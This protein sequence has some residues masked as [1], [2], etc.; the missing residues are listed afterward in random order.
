MF[1]PLKTVMEERDEYIDGLDHGILDTRKEMENILNTLKKKE[2][3]ARDEAHS[4]RLSLEEE[5]SR[6]S[7][8]IHDD[9]MKSVA[10]LR[11]KT[12]ADVARQ[13]DEARKHLQ[14]E[15]EVLAVSIMEKVLNRRLAS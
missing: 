10:E 5:G 12:E 1:R 3:A 8:E 15:S 7:N 14:K 4:I 6:K 2:K 13:I 11:R 9:F